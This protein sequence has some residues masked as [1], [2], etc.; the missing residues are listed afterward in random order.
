MSLFWL[1]YMHY[2]AWKGQ[3]WSTGLVCGKLNLTDR[4][5]GGQ[6]LLLRVNK[7][8][9]AACILVTT[10]CSSFISQILHR[11]FLNIFIQIFFDRQGIEPAAGQQGPDGRLHSGHHHPPPL[12][13]LYLPHFA[14]KY[15][16]GFQSNIF[17]DLTDRG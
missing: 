13:I 5:R 16:I 12:G 17:W 10:P 14:Q 2:W 3:G 1:K 8:Q 11:I 15:L 9:M 7:V 6:L 4:G